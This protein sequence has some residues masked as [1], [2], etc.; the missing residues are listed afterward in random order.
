MGRPSRTNMRLQLYSCQGINSLIAA[1]ARPNWPG[2]GRTRP[3]GNDRG[4]V[5]CPSAGRSRRAEP[6]RLQDVLKLKLR[7]PAAE[8]GDPELAEQAL[9]LRRRQVDAEAVQQALQPADAAHARAARQAAQQLAE[10]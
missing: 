4:L 1:A 3:R 5:A 9:D 7:E 6:E 2:C 8:V 10:Q